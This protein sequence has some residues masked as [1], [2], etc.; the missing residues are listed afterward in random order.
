MDDNKSAMVGGVVFLLVALVVAGYFG[1]QKY[2]QYAFEKEFGKPLISLCQSPGSDGGRANEFFGP[3][4]PKPWRALVINVDHEDE[5]HSK[6]P[7]EARADKRADVDVV[8]CRMGKEQ[9]VIEQ[10]PYVDSS[11]QQYVVQRY[12]RY[13]DFAVLNPTTGKRVADLRVPGPAPIACPPSMH[14]NDKP[15]VGSDPGFREFYYSLLD[16]TWR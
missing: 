15:L 16:V 3:D 8:V 6:L 4:K 7:A 10:C 1:Y 5:W 9:V 14:V 11:G 13:Q 2:T 12:Q